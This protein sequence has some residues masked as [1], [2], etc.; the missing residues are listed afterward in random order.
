MTQEEL[1]KVQLCQLDLA[2][3]VKRI[4]EKHK[5]RFT[6]VYGSLLG[7]VRHNGF[8]PWDDDLDIAMLRTDYEKFLNIC[9]TELDKKYILCTYNTDKNY[10]NYFA[11][12]RI[13]NT[14]Y[15][16]KIS[17]NTN[18]EKGIFIDIYPYDYCSENKIIQLIEITL[19]KSLRIAL[20]TKK[21]YNINKH[22][23]LIK[24][25]KV[26]CRF[27]SSESLIKKMNKIALKR[28]NS[29]FVCSFAGPYKL[30]ECIPKVC[31]NSFELCKFEN[32]LF[33]ILSNS[34]KVLK[35][36]YGDFMTPP[37]PDKRGNRHEITKVD[38][39]GYNIKSK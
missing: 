5:L 36:W 6:L 29:E 8:I 14:L 12:I 18:T 35:Q 19:F 16:Q 26:L 3:E 2:I 13:K 1:H 33:P 28:K 32:Q 15:S 39:N 10:G 25:I 11:Q 30:G 7:A 27:I 9:K 17:E 24:I 34:S 31:F 22:H 23:M 21:G 4:C 38:F 37:A 20:M